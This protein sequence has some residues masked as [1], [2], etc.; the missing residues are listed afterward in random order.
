M[1]LRRL[2]SMFFVLFCVISITFLLIRISPGG[3]FDGE[4]KI[5]PAIE[6]Q[7]LCKYRL[8]GSLWQQYTAYWNDLLHGDLRI[9]TKYRNRSVLEILAQTLPVTLALGSLALLLA[10][11]FGIILGSLWAINPQSIIQTIVFLFVLL[12]L[13]LPAFILGP[14]LIL[15]FAIYLHWFPVG[16][17]GSFLQVVLPA[18]TLA[19]PF[20]AVIANL[21]RDSLRETLQAS[22]I[23]TARAK[24]LSEYSLLYNHALRI[25]ILPVVSYTG[26]LAANLLTGSIV[27][28]TIFHIPGTGVFFVNA[29]LNR[30]GFLLCGVV[31]VYCTLL[32]VFNFMVDLAYRFLDP[33]IENN[34]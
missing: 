21:L 18:I 20:V 7:L 33:R 25:A 34:L 9:S 14:L 19:I 1:L 26:P 29:I 32:I 24:G 13:S 22:F 27:V 28:E 8:D 12:A 30:D 16:G 17:W 15:I 6:H 4:R 10:L 31:M 5:S 11:S 3:P 23:T 2:V